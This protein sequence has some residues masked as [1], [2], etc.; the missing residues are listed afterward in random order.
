MSKNRIAELINNYGLEAHPEGGYFK[1]TYRG[2]IELKERSNLTSIYFLLETGNISHFHSIKSDELWYHHEGDALRI[3]MISPEG[4]YTY[5]DLGSDFSK[6]QKHQG[7]VPANYIF[8]SE[9]IDGEKGFGFVACAV[10]PGFDFDDFR[11]YTEE[12]MLAILPNQEE[13][14]QRLT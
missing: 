10:S 5:F 12:E 1:E 13:L 4:V 2:E 7:M 8:G 11:L 9:L 3:H 6:G 14:V